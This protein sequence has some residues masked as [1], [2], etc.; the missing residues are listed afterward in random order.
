MNALI[1]TCGMNDNSTN[2]FRYDRMHRKIYGCAIEMDWNLIVNLSGLFFKLEVWSESYWKQLQKIAKTNHQD[3]MLWGWC[4]SAYNKRCLWM[5]IDI[6]LRNQN[7]ILKVLWNAVWFYSGFPNPVSIHFVELI[8]A[9][10]F[11]SM[12]E[13]LIYKASRLVQKVLEWI[14]DVVPVQ[15]NDPKQ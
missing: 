4:G 11:G 3:G 1:S 5:W 9:N 15:I 7:R 6:I 10:A 14:D 8:T 2:E 13:S 12:G